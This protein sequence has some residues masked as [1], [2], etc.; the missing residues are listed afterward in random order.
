MYRQKKYS[1][2]QSKARWRQPEPETP[3]PAP[4]FGPLVEKVDIA[5]LSKPAAQFEA[6]ARVTNCELVASYNWLDKTAPSILVPG[7]PPRWTPL[8]KPQ[9]LK[10]DSGV[11]YR[12]KNAARYP[13]HPMEPAVQAVLTKHPE[14]FKKPVDIVGCGSTI[15]NLLRFVRGDERPFRMLVEVVG[16]AVHLIRRENSPTETIP[17]V[18]GYGHT[19]PEAYT[20]WNAGVRGSASHQRVLRYDFGGL[21]CVVRHEGDGYLEDKLGS[22]PDE[23][24][25]VVSKKGSVDAL[26]QDLVAS[27]MESKSPSHSSQLRLQSGGFQV[28]QAAIFDL[29]TRSMFRK[30]QD[31]LGEELP[32]MW[33]AQIPNF[34]LA[35]HQR[36]TFT[37]IEVMDVSEEVRVWEKSKQREL[38]QLAALLHRIVDLAHAS[39]DGRLEL[40]RQEL[41]TLDVRK[42]CPGLSPAFSA[43]TMTKWEHWLAS[44]M[45]SKVS[46]AERRADDIEKE[47]EDEFSWGVGDENDYTA[48]SEK[49]SYCGKCTY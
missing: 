12:D 42:Q 9:Q 36:G 32:R 14:P 46:G 13:A 24:R 34:I 41:S 47:A 4:P 33:V 5:E 11:Y 22:L 37:E 44:D 10:E 15:G 38:S 2:F 43:D 20:T 19:F 45:E 35:Y 6:S 48:C 39:R 49:C 29:K 8:A 25:A 23:G 18:R 1:Q 17:S 21:S 16:G 40:S 27:E 30:G 7:A 3:S 28:P 26:I 31:F